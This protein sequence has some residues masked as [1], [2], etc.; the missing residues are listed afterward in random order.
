[1]FEEKR[2]ED[3]GLPG[4]SDAGEGRVLHIC[5]SEKKGVCKHEVP[6]ANVVAGHG[7]EGDAHSGDWHR[8]VSLLA[9]LDIEFMRSKGL[10]LAPGAFGENFVVDGLNTDELGVGSRLRIG[11]VLLE[12]TQVGKVCHTRCAIYYTTG[13]CIMPRTGL[14]ARVLEGGVVSPGMLATVFH[15]VPRS[16]IQ[17]AVVTVSDRCSEG[18]TIDTAGPAVAK[19]LRD[20]LNVRIAWAALVPDEVARVSEILTDFADRRVDLVVTVG[21]TGMSPRDVTPE[22]TR[23]VLDRELPGL[24]EAMRASSARI[25]P[26]AFLSRAI[27]GIRRETLIV[28]LPGST[29][30]ALENLTAIL[31]ALPHAMEMLRNATAH[32][33]AD[34]GRLV[35]LKASSED[36]KERVAGVGVLG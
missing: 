31:P 21:G 30:A 7:L 1:M 22:A 14:F 15:N 2:L 36:E 16:T 17:A 29:K 23:M 27:A 4:R 26:N 25:T 8:Q 28:N 19:L 32:P 9:H 34:A 6:A 11:P 18:T 3:I 5:V 10:S 35:K 13:D 24:G 20:E 12:L 33:E